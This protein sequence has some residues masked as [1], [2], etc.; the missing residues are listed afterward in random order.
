[1]VYLMYHAIRDRDLA[2]ILYLYQFYSV[3]KWLVY[4]TVNASLLYT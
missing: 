2:M 3:Q 4:H 1:M